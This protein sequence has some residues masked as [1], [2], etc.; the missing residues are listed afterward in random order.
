MAEIKPVEWV[1]LVRKTTT[2]EG[3]L[4]ATQKEPSQKKTTTRTWEINKAALGNMSADEMIQLL[5][6]LPEN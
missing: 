6:Q 2:E 5:R 4:F 1:E 3:L